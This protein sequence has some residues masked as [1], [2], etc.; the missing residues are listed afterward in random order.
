MA[1][2]YKQKGRGCYQ[3]AYFDRDGRRKVVRGYR[4]KKATEEL[5][6]QIES[7]LARDEV[8]LEEKSKPQ[9]LKEKVDE[10]VDELKQQGRSPAYLKEI[11]RV[12]AK[13][14][15]ELSWKTTKEIREE[16]IRKWLVDYPTESP[17]TRNAYLSTI[18]GFCEWAQNK[19]YLK[20]NPA[21]G[22][23]KYRKAGK[24]IRARRAYSLEEF[25]RL[26]KLPESRNDLLGGGI[27]RTQEER[28]LFVGKARRQVRSEASM[29]PA[30]GGAKSG[31]REILPMLAECARELKPVWE[32]AKSDDGR[33]LQPCRIPGR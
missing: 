14:M 19:K 22:I 26:I 33:C 32:K 28:N 27:E 24:K 17:T 25:R 31:R 3:I 4:D 23:K 21:R 8:G 10:Y 20:E 29:A 7:R 5:A 11:A 13:L 12:W 9:P 2:V 30:S 6:R 18:S 1:S 15:R 16:T